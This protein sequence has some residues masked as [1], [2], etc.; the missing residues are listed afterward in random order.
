MDSKNRVP[1]TWEN[2]PS[3]VMVPISRGF[4]YA[5]LV[6]TIVNEAPDKELVCLVNWGWTTSREKASQRIDLLYEFADDPKLALMR[7]L[8]PVPG[9]EQLIIRASFMRNT[10]SAVEASNLYDLAEQLSGL[11][12]RK[13][14]N[15]K[16]VE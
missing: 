2:L 3:M 10:A 5:E 6:K 11:A 13:G 8:A 4:S 7:F 16:T 12:G 15:T 1:R 9:Q 14:L